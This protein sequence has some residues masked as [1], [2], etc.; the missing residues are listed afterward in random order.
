MMSKACEDKT[1]GR[2]EGRGGFL[3]GEEC[4]LNRA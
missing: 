2:R 4:E 3:L 1:E